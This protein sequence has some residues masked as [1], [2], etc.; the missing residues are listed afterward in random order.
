MDDFEADWLDQTILATAI[1][2]IV[3][4]FNSL[5]DIGWYGSAF[6]LTI[7]AFSQFW[8]KTYTYFSL[9]WVLMTAIVIFE[10]GSLICGTFSLESALIVLGEQPFDPIDLSG[11]WKHE[12]A[13]TLITTAVAKNS[14]TLI[15]GRAIAGAGGAGIT[16]GCY[17]IIG[18]VAKP[19]KRP[20]Y[21]GLL[22]A[23]YGLASVVG[24]LIGGAFTTNVTWRWWYVRSGRPTATLTEDIG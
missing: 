5:D 22:A 1:P 8:G 16:N 21:T 23:M 3:Q 18:V 11:P 17:T 9:K 6:F 24:P 15:V 12:L 20:A 7:S 19:E 14:P 2:R 13:N 10:V 4:E